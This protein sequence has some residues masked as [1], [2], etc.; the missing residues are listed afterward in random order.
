M[1][2]IYK[3]HCVPVSLLPYLMQKGAREK[4]NVIYTSKACDLREATHQLSHSHLGHHTPIT[5]F[6]LVQ[7][8][9]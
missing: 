7:G 3:V 4:K 9:F 8:I 1:R 2:V 5:S 6:I